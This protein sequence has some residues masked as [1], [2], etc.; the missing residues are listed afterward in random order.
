VSVSA[1][2]LALTVDVHLP[3]CRSLKAKRSVLKSVIE[4]SRRRFGVSVAETDHQD[5]WQRAEIAVAVVSS[6]ARHA[7]EV[8]DEVERFVWSVPELQVLSVTRR[9]MEY[10]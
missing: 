8:I 4:S 7:V 9:W 6:S 3:E 10:D 5:T 1:H 2:V